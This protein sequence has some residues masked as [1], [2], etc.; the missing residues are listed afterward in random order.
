MLVILIV[1]LLVLAF[2]GFRFAGPGN[3]PY[4]GGGLGFVIVILLI[5][6]LLGYLRN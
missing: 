5:L 4:V 3:G 1:V 2:G 6:Y